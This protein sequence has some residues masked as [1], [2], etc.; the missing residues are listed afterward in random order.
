MPENRDA[1]LSAD[2]PNPVVPSIH[3]A[4]GGCQRVSMES[5]A[6]WDFCTAARGAC[7]KASGHNRE[8]FRTSGRQWRACGI[9]QFDRPGH[10][11]ASVVCARRVAVP[12]P[13]LCRSW[14]D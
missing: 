14:L 13:D 11:R 1:T 5:D 3:M 10:P 12:V 6:F 9:D 8:D 2:A 4:E 7:Q